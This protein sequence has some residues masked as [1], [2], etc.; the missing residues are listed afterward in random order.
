MNSCV[1][2]ES[3]VQRLIAEIEAS[4]PRPHHA[5]LLAAAE[6]LIPDCP[7]RFALTRGG[8]Y[9]TGGLFRADG[10]RLTDNLNDWLARELAD[11]DDDVAE[12][13]DRHTDGELVATRHTGRTH[14][15]VAPYGAAPAEFLQL[16]VEELQEVLDRRLWDA[17]SPPA[18]AQE[19]ADPIKP[20]SVPAQAVGAPYYRFRR[21]TDLR[22]VVARQSAPPGS[23]PALTRLM[24]EWAAS[25]AGAHFSEHWIVALR[26]HQ[27]RYNNAVLAATPVSRHERDLKPFHWNSDLRGLDAAKQLQTFD[28]AAGYPGAWYFHLV[29]G[30]LTPRDMA[31]AVMRDIES[32]FG[33]LSDVEAAL[34]TGWLREPYSV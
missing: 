28:R 17:A 12:F 8:W 29:A 6:R 30:G 27:D 14:Y 7:C 31:F 23:L 25:R 3:T 4:T 26:E 24:Q 32:G 13:M 20:A 22:Q 9:R 34:L 18:D 19:L 16:E 1:P 10:E 11:C 5:S 33:Y 2:D 21:L 15:F